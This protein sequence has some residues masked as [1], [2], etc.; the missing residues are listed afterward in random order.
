MH[1]NPQQQQ[2]MNR[3]L[4]PCCFQNVRV[5]LLLFCI[6]WIS[7]LSE[8]HLLYLFARTSLHSTHSTITKHIQL[9]Q[10][11][12]LYQL[13]MFWITIF[14]AISWKHASMSRYENSVWVSVIW[15][16]RD[17]LFVGPSSFRMFSFLLC[18]YNFYC[19]ERLFTQRWWSN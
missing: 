14:V 16:S 9:F 1:H 12:K 7:V 3:L 15:W 18:L 19:R 17:T 13:Y 8:A 2:S 6:L 4:E 5:F 11:D 10:L